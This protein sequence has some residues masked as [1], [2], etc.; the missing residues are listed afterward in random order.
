VY[1]GDNNFKDYV[2]TVS[3]VQQPDGNFIEPRMY[4]TGDGIGIFGS[5]IRDT[6]TFNLVP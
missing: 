4:L 3:N 2:L 6:V 5:A 1:A